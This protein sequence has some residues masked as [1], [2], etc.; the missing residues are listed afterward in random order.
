MSYP[1]RAEGLVNS[2]FW[3][4]CVLWSG[5]WIICWLKSFCPLN[6]RHRLHKERPQQKKEARFYV[7]IFLV[8]YSGILHRSYFLNVTSIIFLKCYIVSQPFLNLLLWHD[9][10]VLYYNL[11]ASY[12]LSHQESGIRLDPG[13]FLKVSYLVA[14]LHLVFFFR[15][16]MSR[17]N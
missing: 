11:S 2:T 1:A 3:P 14:S 9:T 16:S 13:G 10:D 17:L 6:D 5:R 12:V 7:K 15:F 4:R 8:I